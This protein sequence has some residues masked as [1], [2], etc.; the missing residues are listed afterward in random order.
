MYF[1]KTEDTLGQSV[2]EFCL[3]CGALISF[4]SGCTFVL[5]SQWNRARCAYLVFEKAHQRLI[6]GSSDSHHGQGVQELGVC[7]EV[8]ERVDLPWLEYARW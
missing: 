8:E 7:G 2:I 4:L 6:C 3:S 5:N 1:F